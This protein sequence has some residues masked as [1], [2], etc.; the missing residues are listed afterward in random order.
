MT[1]KGCPTPG[2]IGHASKA[3]A[4]REKGG[5]RSKGKRMRAYLCPCGAW[6]LAS[7]TKEEFGE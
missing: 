7:W 1:V 3:A 4:A 5:H 6:H 2:K